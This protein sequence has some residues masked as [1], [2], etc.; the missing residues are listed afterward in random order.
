MGNGSHIKSYPMM[1]TAVDAVDIDP[2]GVFKY[3]LIKLK[4]EEDK[5]I[6][7]G[8]KWGEYHADI[9]EKVEEDLKRDHGVRCSC[10]G[11][12]RINHDSEKKEILVYGHSI[13]YGRADHAKTVKL[14]K[15]RYPD[16]DICF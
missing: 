10:H 9:F 15:I 8:Y 3:V 11:G 5:Y 13:G 2:S 7:R 6:V 14:L 16:Y 12:G 4:G 1:A